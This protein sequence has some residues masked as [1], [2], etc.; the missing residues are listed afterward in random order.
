MGTIADKLA[1]LNTTK[2]E[3]KAALAEKGQT[4]GEVFSAYPAA[5]RAIEAGSSIETATVTVYNNATGFYPDPSI[6][7]G[8]YDKATGIIS[9]H[10]HVA[11]KGTRATIQNVAKN[12]VIY[13]NKVTAFSCSISGGYVVDSGG[14][15]LVVT[16]DSSEILVENS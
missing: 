7:F 3:L 13:V 16:D 8:I 6:A 1:K 14:D 2:E 9:V 12:S 4:V 10:S 5:V 15:Y 11:M